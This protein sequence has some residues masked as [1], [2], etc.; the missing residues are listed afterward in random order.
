MTLQHFK[1]KTYC[2]VSKCVQVTQFLL[3]T[4]IFTRLIRAQRGIGYDPNAVELP[5]PI[6]FTET[7]NPYDTY[8]NA[9]PGAPGTRPSPCQESSCYPATGDLLI[10]R[11]ERLHARLVL[12][13][14]LAVLLRI[15]TN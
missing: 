7:G 3:L 1:M 2:A 14:E 9:L 8:P 6:Y 10:G 4:L 13:Q 11:E 12:L 15:V 5:L